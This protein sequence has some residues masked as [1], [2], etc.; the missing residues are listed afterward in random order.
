MPVGAV[1]ASVGTL[2]SVVAV[3][4]CG[5]TGCIRNGTGSLFT[6]AMAT[7]MEQLLVAATSVVAVVVVVVA[8][9]VVHATTVAATAFA[10]VQ[11]L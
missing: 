5:K 10:T 4:V 7:Y 3:G 2:A 1:S 6:V 11:K 8:M 9:A